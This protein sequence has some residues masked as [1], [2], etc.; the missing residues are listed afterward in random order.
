MYSGYSGWES[1]GFTIMKPSFKAKKEVIVVNVIQCYAPN[2]D[3]D[4]NDKD[5]FYG[6]PQLTVEKCP[7]QDLTI[8]M[9]D[10][11]VKLGMDNTR[12]E[13]ITGR[14]GPIKMNVFGGR[15]TNLYAFNKI[16]I[17]GTLFPYKLIY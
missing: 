9:G 17:D 7:E 2:N 11:Y 6:T 4:E 13:Y 5:Q 12:Y 3:G 14:H 1:H 15:F 8:L 16:V 10:L